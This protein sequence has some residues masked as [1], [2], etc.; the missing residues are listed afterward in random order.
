[1]RSATTNLVIAAVIGA[2]ISLALLLLEQPTDFAW[3]SLEMPGI[4]AAY[5]VW[6]ATGGSSFAGIAICWLVNALLYGLFAFAV[7]V[8]VSAIRL[9]V[10]AN[11]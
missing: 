6:G 1:M 3:L 11:V 8:A 5:Y 2:M 10:R 4:T 7:L 9:S